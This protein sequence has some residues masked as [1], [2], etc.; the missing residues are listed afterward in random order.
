MAEERRKIPGYPDRF[1]ISSSGV[2][3]RDGV[4]DK[5]VCK[6][7]GY[8]VV[9]IITHDGRRKLVYR[10]RLVC[11]A[12]H[13]M[14]PS[15]NH[16]VAHRDG[17][18]DHIHKS[19]L[20][21]ATKIENADDRRLHGT[22][23]AGDLNPRAVLDAVAVEELRATLVVSPGRKRL[24]RGAGL[25]AAAAKKYGVTKETIWNAVRGRT[26]AAQTEERK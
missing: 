10:H 25:V 23:P 19:N 15:D 18:R 20:R 14:P 9:T 2:L 4:P 22:H 24:P 26:W 5:A 12:F 21:W 11:L 17:V 7:R 8:P 6:V 1:E 13:G 16:E 3:Y